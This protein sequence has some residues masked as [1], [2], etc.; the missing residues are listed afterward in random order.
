M[1]LKLISHTRDQPRTRAV[2]ILLSKGEGAGADPAALSRPRRS[3]P[4]TR[5]RARR[6]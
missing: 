4:Y 5:A 1:L 6:N 2:K 3:P